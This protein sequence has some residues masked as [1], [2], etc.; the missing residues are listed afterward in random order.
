MD[1]VKTQN[2]TFTYPGGRTPAIKNISITAG[3]GEFVTVCGKSGCGKSTLLRQLKPVL[4]PCGDVSGEIYFNGMEIKGLSLREQ[5]EKIGFV[6][7]DPDNQIVTDKV[8]HE[9]AFGLEN[10]GTPPDQIRVRVAEMVSFFGIGDW[11]YKSTTQLSGGQKQI[12]NLASVMVMR[13]QLLILDEPTSQLDPV[14]AQNFLETLSRINREIGTTVIMTEHRLEEAFAISDRVIVMENGEIIAD[15]SPEKVGEILK[16]SGNDMYIA[17]P[18][19]MRVHF[20]V[21]NGQ[22][23]PVTVREGKKWLEKMEVNRG[24]VF[25]DPDC[26]C[27]ESAVKVKDVWLR[28]EKNLPDVLK[29][30]SINIK[31]GEIYAVTGGNGA[32][33]TTLVSAIAGLCKAYRGKILLGG[34][35]SMMPQ[36]PRTLFGEKTVELELQEMA[37]DY[38]RVAQLCELEGLLEMHPSDL[39]G[40][41]AQKV[42][43]AKVLL[44]NPEI[45]LLDEPT[46]G[47]DAHFKEKFAG[48]L[49]NLAQNGMTVIMVSHDI[50]FCAK[51]ADRCGLLFDGIIVSEA[52]PRSFFA[53]KS[54]YTT[55]ANR[56][57]ADVISDA[58]VAEDI[59]LACGG[60]LPPEKKG[61]EKKIAP[62]ERM[63]EK[64]QRKISPKNIALSV[65]FA[66][67]FLICHFAPV[68]RRSE[69][70]NILMLTAEF[71]FLAIALTRL[72]P[73][74]QIVF[75]AKTKKPGWENIVSVTAAFILVPLTVYIGTQY[76]DGRKYYLISMLVIAETFLPFFIL[77][78]QRKAKARELVLVSVI[79]AAAVVG[80]EAFFML[81]Q[82][83]PIAAIV[84]IAGVCFGGETGFLAGAVSAFVSNFFF[85][86]SMMTPWQML[87]LGML[88]FLAG[89]IFRSGAVKLTRF[90]LCLFGGISVI[91]VHGGILN[92][93]SLLMWQENPTAEM[94]LASYIAGFWFDVTY[95]ISTVFFLWV[96][97]VPM[98]EKLERVKTKYN[99]MK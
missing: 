49:K 28:Y 50:E 46:K 55:A 77:F 34:R 26:N 13:P 72:I 64:K 87:A 80:R 48:I 3:R 59:I 18:T 74:R 73:Q 5:A 89:V 24:M 45:L 30:L 44:S 70:V 91:L 90:N 25:P 92:P 11:F 65:A 61:E 20:A 31:K 96:I 52:A 38:E 88:G 21:P 82:F 6:M 99:L 57:A 40:G 42:A 63:P 62:R 60:T 22:K 79:C 67:L 84:I 23:C 9:L 58:I 66:G 39:S 94:F 1:I 76:F 2:L 32:G 53:G 8:W 27:G 16:T 12:L 68:D 35:I 14:A 19:P 43:L 37:E 56:M 29:G 93:A 36:N 83:K 10:L 47:L 17:L 98:I 78:E 69:W 97:S 15:D 85:G 7:Q 81:P 4:S 33:K 71:I 41:E 95:A 51:Y 75:S 54:F 86:Q